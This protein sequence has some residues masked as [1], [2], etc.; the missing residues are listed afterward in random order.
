MINDKM[1]EYNYPLRGA[2]VGFGNAAIH[3]HLPLWQNNTRFRIDAVVEPLKEQADLAQ[4]LLPEAR[5]YSNIEPLFAN[6]DLDFIDICT[7]P[8]FHAE[9]ILS[10][11]RSGLHVFCEK[12]LIGTLEGLDEIRK[13]AETEKRV[14][15]I[16]NNWK[17]SPLWMKVA[18]LLD[19]NKIGAVRDISLT[20]L[21]TT[22]S[23]GGISDW[24]QCLQTASGG[25]LTDHGW[26]QIYL[27]PS[28]IKQP[29][30]SIS[31]RMTHDPA[32]D[33]QMEETV[34]LV[35]R[36]PD[37]EARLHLTWRA[38]CRQNCGTIIG[39]GGKLL[40]N[41]DHLILNMNNSPPVRYDFS[42]ALS[43][44]SHHPDWM[45]PVIEDFHREIVNPELRGTNFKEA[46]WCRKIT[47]LAYRSHAKGSSFV[48]VQAS[49]L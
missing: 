19:E 22:Q 26:H 12:P 48:R 37:A 4:N 27:I 25:I 34:D 43:A 47:D 13:A 21:R 31:A 32:K 16:V 11:C 14:L 33:P 6:N 17:Y 24:R 39:Q 9:L 40:I 42:E 18:E 3:A 1:P 41:D 30:V 2:L 7:P 29:P 20:V 36:F 38:S 44:G 35:L 10:A 5:I 45:K 8:C 28:I 23:G 46:V 49:M 15:F